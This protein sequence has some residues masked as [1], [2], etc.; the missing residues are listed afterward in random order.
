MANET[1]LD[2]S[3]IEAVAYGGFTFPLGQLR[4]GDRSDLR[5]ALGP[6]R[7]NKL[8]TEGFFLIHMEKNNKIVQIRIKS[9]KNKE[10]EFQ[11]SLEIN[12][13]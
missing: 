6:L 10:G 9:Y 5:E 7:W 3:G 12:G 8:L 4:F 13:S 1:D 11:I 2:L